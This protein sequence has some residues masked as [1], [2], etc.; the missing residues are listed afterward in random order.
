M[1]LLRAM[2]DLFVSAALP[3]SSAEEEAESK[4]GADPRLSLAN[5]V[6]KLPM[7]AELEIGRSGSRAI[8]VC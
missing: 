7:G 2:T 3:R 1:L 4:A 6:E 5:P 8:Y